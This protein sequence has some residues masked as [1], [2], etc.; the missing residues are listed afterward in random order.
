[1]ESVSELERVYASVGQASAV[2]MCGRE[3]IRAWTNA[4][5]FRHYR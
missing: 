3:Q 1:M 5:T 4:V 2:G